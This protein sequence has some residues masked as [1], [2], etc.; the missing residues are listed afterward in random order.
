MDTVEIIHDLSEPKKISHGLPAGVRRF[1]SIPR[2]KFDNVLHIT[3]HQKYSRIVTRDEIAKNDFNI[4]TSRYI[5]TGAGEEYRPIAE[6]VEELNALEEEE[7]ATDA[8]L[9]E[10]LK[11]IGV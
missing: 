5:H 10:I 4:S 6:I 11:R 8:A 1:L 7:K 2:E 3:H 9:K